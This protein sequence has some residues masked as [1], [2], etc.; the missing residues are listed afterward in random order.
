MNSSSERIIWLKRGEVGF[1]LIA[2]QNNSIIQSKKDLDYTF[3]W[4]SVPLSGVTYEWL[5][6]TLGADLKDTAGIV[7]KSAN[8]GENAGIPITYETLEDLMGI[9]N[10]DYLDTLHGQWTSRAL[11]AGGVEYSLKTYAISIIRARPVGL[12][13]FTSAK[14][15]VI[16]P[17]P[18]ENELNV[19]WPDKLKVNRIKLVDVS[20][21][22]ILIQSTS[23]N[24]H[25]IT[26]NVSGIK[27]GIYV[28]NLETDTDIL[29]S[30]V[31]IR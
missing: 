27:S 29:K 21:K 28:L 10:V 2:P 17:N 12:D 5:F 15:I 22:N 9:Y 11:H 6:D 16:F 23:N 8:S 3:V 7:F 24:I 20:G 31:L 25:E 1:S 19:S 4:D 14:E 13:E 18:A 30:N 26:L